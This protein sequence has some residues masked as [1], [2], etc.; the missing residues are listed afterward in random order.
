MIGYDSLE[1]WR[2]VVDYEGLY[3]VSNLGNVKRLI[4]GKEKPMKLCTNTW[5]YQ[6][7]ILC[8]KGVSK[9]RTVHQIVA[10]AFLGHIPCGFKTQVDHIDFNKTNNKLTNLRILSQRENTSKKKKPHSSI[11]TGVCWSKQHGKWR[12]VLADKYKRYHLGYFT[13]EHEAGN[14]YKTF[15]NKLESGG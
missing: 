1:E 6:H 12:V 2:D 5:G 7:V 13:D 4:S 9:C 3:K 14:A 11:Y 10:Q 15:L 8:K